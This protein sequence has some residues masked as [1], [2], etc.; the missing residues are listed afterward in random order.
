MG[1]GEGESWRSHYRTERGKVLGLPLRITATSSTSHSHSFIGLCC[2]LGSDSAP[3][4]PSDCRVSLAA[5]H[6]C[7]TMKLYASRQLRGPMAQIGFDHCP[8]NVSMCIDKDCVH[9]T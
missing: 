2:V 1:G 7:H 5:Q 8:N 9:Y 3:G 4:C 6:M